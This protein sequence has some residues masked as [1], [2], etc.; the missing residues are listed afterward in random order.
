MC[1]NGIKSTIE[2][3][4]FPAVVNQICTASQLCAVA[5]IKGTYHGNLGQM[6]LGACVSKD[7]CSDTAG[8]NLA[9]RYLPS[10]ATSQE[11]KVL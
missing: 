6:K 11:C 3:I 5:T 10:G 9:L 8:C 2:S 4:K 7:N 1:N